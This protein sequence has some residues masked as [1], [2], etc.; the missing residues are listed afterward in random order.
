MYGCQHLYD[1]SSYSRVLW[2]LQSTTSSEQY[3]FAY[4]E[5]IQMRVYYSYA[6]SIHSITNTLV[7]IQ[8]LVCIYNMHTTMHRLVLEYLVCI[9]PQ[10]QLVLVVS[11]DYYS[12]NIHTVCMHTVVW[13]ICIVLTMHTTNSQYQYQL[14][15][16]YNIIYYM[17]IM[18]TSSQQ[19]YAQCQSMDESYQ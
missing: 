14:E 16:A 17:H 18:H 13:I 6:Y 1:Q 10:Y 3:A 2:I 4:E 8:L 15:Y 5:S 11:Y 12:M 7:V 19:F 9:L